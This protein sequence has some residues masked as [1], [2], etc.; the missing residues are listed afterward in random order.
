LFG[1]LVVVG[2]SIVLAVHL[3]LLARCANNAFT[4]D[5]RSI[6]YPVASVDHL[7]VGSQ[8]IMDVT[9]QQ[10]NDSTS[11]SVVVTYQGRVSAEEYL[12]QFYL[13]TQESNL[14]I[15]RVNLNFQVK[16]HFTVLNLIVHRVPVGMPEI[17]Y[18]Y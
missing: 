10:S 8:I 17:V 4:T 15:N 6:S 11:D 12:S 7:F 1:C 18:N 5:S 2:G 9:V 16:Y 13:D 3:S 14:Q